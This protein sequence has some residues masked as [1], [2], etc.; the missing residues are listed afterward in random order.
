[1]LPSDANRCWIWF[2][3]M[4]NL[5]FFLAFQSCNISYFHSTFHSVGSKGF[6][7]PPWKAENTSQMK[8]QRWHPLLKKFHFSLEKADDVFAYVSKIKRQCIIAYLQF[9][10]TFKC[11]VSLVLVAME[12]GSITHWKYPPCKILLDLKCV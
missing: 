6:N 8:N 9:F 5:F 10:I 1:M 7:F 12:S 4:L 2:I 11:K 3:T